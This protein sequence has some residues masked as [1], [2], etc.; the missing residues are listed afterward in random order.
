MDFETFERKMGKMERLEVSGRISRVENAIGKSGKPYW[1]VFIDGHEKPLYVWFKN[2][3]DGMRPGG[4]ANFEV[5]DRNGFLN[6]I[7]ASPIGPDE[8]IMPDEDAPAPQLPPAPKKSWVVPDKQ[9]NPYITRMSCLKTAVDF[10]TGGAVKVD[11]SI[12]DVIATAARFAD[13][14]ETGDYNNENPG[15]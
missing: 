6:V 4:G 2:I 5:E 12:E 8:H 3:L 14:V 10:L 11:P 7:K 13:Y 1:K 9:N 15:L